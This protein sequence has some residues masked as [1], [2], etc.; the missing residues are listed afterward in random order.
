MIVPLE[1]KLHEDVAWIAEL[2]FFFLSGIV[3][4]LAYLVSNSFWH[5]SLRNHKDKCK[6]Q[7]FY[8]KRGENEK[9]K[10]R[11]AAAETV[12]IWKRVAR[13]SFAGEVLQFH[14]LPFKCSLR[15]GV[16]SD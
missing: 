6:P 13:K 14:F 11:F 16:P 1:R 8:R 12:K 9:S 7:K 3:A 2:Q 5:Q 4:V 15:Q 10:K